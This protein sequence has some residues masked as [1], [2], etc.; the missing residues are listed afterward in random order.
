LAIVVVAVCALVGRR[1]APAAEV[2]WSMVVLPDTQY[3]D[4]PV[5]WSIF[6]QM[7]QWIVDNK[8]SRNIELVLHEGDV[9]DQ[10]TDQQWAAA[11]DAMGRLNGEVPYIVTTGNHDGSRDGTKINQ[12][13]H[14][15]DNPLNN[16]PDGIFTTQYIPGEVQ[17]AYSTFTAPDGRK[18]LVF[19]L[20]FMPG[21]DVVGWANSIAAQPQYEGYTAVLLTHA[22]LEEG[23]ATA[24]GEPTAF[25]HPTGTSL[26]NNLV[27]Q[28]GN[29]EMVFNGHFLDGND[30]DPNG[31][32]TAARQSVTGVGGNTVHEMVFNSQQQPNGGNGYMR[33]LEFLDDGRTVEVQTYSPYLDQWLTDDCNQFQLLLSPAVPGD[34]NHDGL[35][36]AA[37]YTAWQDTMHLPNIMPYDSTP[38]VVDQ[39]DYELWLANY[40]RVSVA[41]GDYDDNG[42]VDAGDYT[43]CMDAIHRMRYLLNDTTPGVIDHSDFEVWKENFGTTASAGD[44]NGDGIVDAADYTTWQDAMHRTLYLPNDLTPGIVDESDLEVWKANYGNLDDSAEIGD[45][46]GDGFV[47]DADYDVWLEHFNRTIYMPNDVTFG[48]VD[49]SDFEVWKSE[50]RRQGDSGSGAGAAATQVPE[51]GTVLLA[52]GLWAP[53]CARRRRK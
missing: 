22:Y 48:H 17:N 9:T 28:H 35:V 15:E 20:E 26:W 1:S 11:A 51:P 45:Y 13:F 36:D 42:I 19:S 52:I 25:R 29:F 5:T 8:D 18:M 46:N 4:D 24:D 12:Y 37:D 44:Y 6:N 23:P 49:R 32:L 47:N 16:S 39:S 3:Y 2:S 53:L 33:L 10:N 40:G 31:P 30:T 50:F 14:L 27:G 34:Y 38:G 21:S 41:M 43:V 7:T